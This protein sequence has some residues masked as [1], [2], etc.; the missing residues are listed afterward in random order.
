MADVRWYLRPRWIVAAGLV[1]AV[2]ALFF[3][4]LDRLEQRRALNARIESGL[5]SDPV[6]LADALGSGDPA[7]HRVWVEGTYRLDAELI[8]FGRT[9]D[10]QPGNHVLTPLDTADGPAL[11]IDRGWVPIDLDRPGEARTG[12]PGGPVRLT[13][14]LVPSEDG[15]P[16]DEER[17]VGAIDVGAIAAAEPDLQLVERV[18]L[19]L[20]TQSPAQTGG[21]PRPVPLP[22]LSEGPHLSYA[23]QWFLFAAVAVVGFFFLLRRTGL[24][25][26]GRNRADDR[27]PGD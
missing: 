15:D 12:P 21:L 14:V 18:Y 23:V 10:G 2:A 11:L 16:P 9:L 3:W 5:T 7:F 13:G 17:T 26:R 25:E 1:A 20:E 19:R 6:A 22:P 8:L 24:E 4:Q 27:G